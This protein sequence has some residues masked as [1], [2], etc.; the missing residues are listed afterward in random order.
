MPAWVP[1]AQRVRRVMWVGF[2]ELLAD[3]DAVAGAQIASVVVAGLMAPAFRM[4]AAGARLG[5]HI[6]RVR[7]HHPPDP[8][9]SVAAADAVG[10][11]FGP[12]AHWTHV[13]IET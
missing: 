7:G 4:P 8:T 1:V 12:R 3:L 11:H 9:G 5:L 10:D 13:P 2:A 6:V